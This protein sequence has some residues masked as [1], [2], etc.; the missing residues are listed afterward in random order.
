[1][2]IEKSFE[3]EKLPEVKLPPPTVEQEIEQLSYLRDLIKQNLHLSEKR[4]PGAAKPYKDLLKK[5][6]KELKTAH[7]KQ[8][9]EKTGSNG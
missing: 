9:D 4:G 6:N 8:R 3:A 7:Q 2:E 1:V 5:V